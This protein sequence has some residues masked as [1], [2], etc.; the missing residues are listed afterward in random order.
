MAQ[1]QGRW[2]GTDDREVSAEPSAAAV[3]TARE[4]HNHS[5][6]CNVVPVNGE[7]SKSIR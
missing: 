2:G 3:E 5:S 4:R 7:W 6:I 1:G